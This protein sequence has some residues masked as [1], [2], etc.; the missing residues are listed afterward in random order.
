MNSEKIVIAY[1][2]NFISSNCPAFS[3]LVLTE[4]PS[5]LYKIGLKMH[6]G[7]ELRFVHISNKDGFLLQS[8]KITPGRDLRVDFGFLSG[9]YSGNGFTI[10]IS[11]N[12]WKTTQCEELLIITDPEDT[13]WSER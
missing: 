7:K 11:S 12:E 13:V 4:K 8:F 3:R 6:T 10:A 2:I 9:F 5:I 1:N